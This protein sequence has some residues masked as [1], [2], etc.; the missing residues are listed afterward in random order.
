MTRDERPRPVRI[1]DLGARVVRGPRQDTEKSRKITRWYWRVWRTRGGAEETVATGWWSDREIEKAVAALV[2]K[3]V[4]E[5]GRPR[6]TVRTVRDA[7]EFWMGEM[8]SRG[9]LSPR[10][11]AIRRAG[12]THVAIG[13][14]DVLVSE[15]GR[16]QLERYRD[17]RLREEVTVL[18]KRR[19][20]SGAPVTR[21][22]ARGEEEEVWDAH[23]TGRTT[24]PR[25]VAFE[26]HCLR[27]CWRW[28][29]EI[30]L[31]E[32]ELPRVTVKVRGHVRNR[33]T[34]SP[35]QTAAVMLELD[36]W[37]R[38]ALLLY[39]GTGARLDEIAALT[40]D[41]VDLVQ[42]EL[43]VTGKMGD[44]VVPIEPPLVAAL[45]AI[46]PGEAGARVL[47]CAHSTARAIYDR[48][49]VACR[50]AGVPRFA[51]GA[52]RRAAVVALYRTG[53]PSVAGAIIGHSPTVAMRHYRDVA[54]DEQRD[55][56]RLARLGHLPD[57]DAKVVELP[58]ARRGRR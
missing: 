2:T 14:G 16:L 13:L 21:V 49:E 42:G 27:M 18:R 41:R 35:T 4:A 55:A 9:D 26:I 29:R 30:G 10:T 8:E 58:E 20:P 53:D 52:L 12:A 6:A 17:R 51:P 25:S 45:Q 38:L 36:G 7:L 32:G 39:A 47:A 40:W 24:A 48:L 44:R 1:D 34:P 28:S 31:V 54:K 43:T 5:P 37:A 50:A 57:P 33:F 22:N 56:M 23:P 11:V 19:H 15:L 46:G 3:G